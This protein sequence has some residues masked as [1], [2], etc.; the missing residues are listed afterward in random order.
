MEIWIG[1]RPDW[2]GLELIFQLT[3]C[4]GIPCDKKSR[5]SAMAC[6]RESCSQGRLVPP[7]CCHLLRMRSSASRIGGRV[8]E[9]EVGSSSERGEGAE[10]LMGA[11]TSLLT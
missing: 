8:F 10:M 11:R 3:D 1:N 2:L 6:S 7:G 4:G 5:R 9:A